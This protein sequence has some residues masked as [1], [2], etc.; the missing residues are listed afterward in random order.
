MSTNDT[1]KGKI[2]VIKILKKNDIHVCHWYVKKY[3]W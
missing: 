1:Q 3:M 2:F